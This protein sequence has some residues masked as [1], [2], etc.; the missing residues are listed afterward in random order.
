MGVR[1]RRRV[2][3]RACVLNLKTPT[4]V[5]SFCSVL[6][7]DHLL[8][9]LLRVVLLAALIFLRWLCLLLRFV[10]PLNGRHATAHQIPSGININN[11]SRSNI[12]HKTCA[13]FILVITLPMLAKLD[14]ISPKF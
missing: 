14:N 7:G 8:V 4:T 10:Y 12:S 13:L 1:Y 3:G 2:F 5:S 9:E 6:W 11:C